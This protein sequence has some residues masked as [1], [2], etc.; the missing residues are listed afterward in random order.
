MIGRDAGWL[1]NNVVTTVLLA[2]LAVGLQVQVTLPV[3][4]VGLRV[5]AADLL[6]PFLVAL[7]FVAGRGRPWAAFEW[8]DK[9]TWLWLAVLSAWMAFAV[10]WGRVTIGTWL[11]W[12]VTNKFAGWFVLVGYF[13]LGGFFAGI[14]DSERRAWFLRA[15]LG[16]A[17]IIAL[18]AV[19]A[20]AAYRFDL[21]TTEFDNPIAFRVQGLLDNPNAFGCLMAF[22]IALQAPYLARAELFPRSLHRAGLALMLAAVVLSGSRSAWI[23]TAAGLATVYALKAFDVR[24]TIRA[25]VAAALVV[26]LV[27]FG[28]DLLNLLLSGLGWNDGIGGLPRYEPAYIL[29]SNPAGFNERLR[30]ALEALGLWTGHPLLG[31][32]L[33]GMLARELASGTT[34]V[35]LVHNS[36]LWLL[37]ETGLIGLALFAAFFFFCLRGLLRTA[38]QDPFG[39][40]ATGAFVAMI[41]ASIGIEALYQRHFWFVLGLALALPAA[42]GRAAPRRTA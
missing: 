39:A 27:Y 14:I 38:G 5:S 20:L 30:S 42:A 40:A 26:A 22:L 25:A 37:V 2:V 12:A 13:S 19:A 15:L 24:E 21:L 1:G 10:V 31:T 41:G 17:W 28:R 36:A 29:R 7:A 32:G 9:H 23:A 18:G 35:T 3:S 16:A 33:G 11:G 6:L 34:T 4:E 8:R